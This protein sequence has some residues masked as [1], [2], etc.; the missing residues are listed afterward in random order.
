MG[1]IHAKEMVFPLLNTGVRIPRCIY[2]YIYRGSEALHYLLEVDYHPTSSQM[3]T[4]T[5]GV[6]TRSFCVH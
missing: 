6:R 4:W 2:I 5:D 1:L 3:I